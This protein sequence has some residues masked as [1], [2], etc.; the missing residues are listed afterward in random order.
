MIDALYRS[1][2]YDIALYSWVEGQR[3]I[4]PSCT[5]EQSISMYVKFFAVKR[6]IDSLKITYYRM[7]RKHH[8]TERL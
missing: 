7:Q 5:I 2:F 8:D 3:R 4:I 1:N 6:D